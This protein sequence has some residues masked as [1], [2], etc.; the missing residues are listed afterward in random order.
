MTRRISNCSILLPPLPI[1]SS[2]EFKKHM[3]SFYKS[4][5]C[6]TLGSF[7]FALL[8]ETWL[9]PDQ[10]FFSLFSFNT[11]WLGWQLWYSSHNF[12]IVNC[13]FWS[14]IIYSS[15]SK[16]CL[17][18]AYSSASTRIYHF[19]FFQYRCWYI[20][21]LQHFIINAFLKSFWHSS[22]QQ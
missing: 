21:Y 17:S 9:R 10:G 1:N 14:D 5:L 7:F 15:I 16:C 20:H 19:P 2:V 4:Y 13:I 18:C 6:S 22:Q 12:T 11:L 3:T 8:S